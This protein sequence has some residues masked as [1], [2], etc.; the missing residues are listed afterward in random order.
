MR[1]TDHG[2]PCHSVKPFG[3]IIIIIIIIVIS[4]RKHEPSV[5]MLRVERLS[6]RVHV[7]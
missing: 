3:V 1:A 6:P 4:R 2:G 5:K 7:V